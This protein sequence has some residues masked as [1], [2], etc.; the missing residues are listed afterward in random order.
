MIHTSLKEPLAIHHKC[1]PAL[2]FDQGIITKSEQFFG[3]QLDRQT[4]EKLALTIADK[5]DQR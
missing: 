2:V 4:A 5:V 3:T 1:T